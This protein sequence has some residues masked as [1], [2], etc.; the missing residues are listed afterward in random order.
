MQKVTK[1]IIPVAGMGTRFLPA[2]KAQ[3]KEMLTVIDKPVIQ[4]L[5]EEAVQAGITDIIFVTG[6]NK[7]AIEDH[8]D[9]SPELEALL[10][11]D[12]KTKILEEVQAISSLARFSFVRQKA[13]LGDGDAI[14]C[15]AHLIGNE[16]VG[17]MFGDDIF[18]GSPRLSQIGKIFE[19]KGEVVAALEEVP[20]EEVTRYGVVDGEK[21]AENLYSIKRIV[22]KPKL[23]EAPSNL[24]LMGT[25]IINKEVMDELQI[26]K[27]NTTSGEVRLANALEAYLKKRP[28][29]GLKMDGKRYDCGD[30]LGFLKT[31]VDFA[32]KHPEVKDAFKEY[33]RSVAQ[34]L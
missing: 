15:A 22:E 31:T 6:R 14:L 21:S 3:P 2:T 5:V 16:S 25:Y 30:K 12:N 29:F 27:Q 17:V 32:L 1:L 20:H 7:R 10:A 8:F 13:P 28:V 19:E 24:I 4:Y 18:V 9:S 34:T 23:E 33:L 11:N 26:L